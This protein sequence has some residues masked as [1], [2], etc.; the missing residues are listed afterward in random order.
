MLYAF[1]SFLILMIRTLQLKSMFK[2]IEKTIER[3]QSLAQTQNQMKSCKLFE[4]HKIKRKEK[5][6]Y[7]RM[8]Q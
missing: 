2:S 5:K 8:N 7:F 1:E 6:V 4:R 3:V